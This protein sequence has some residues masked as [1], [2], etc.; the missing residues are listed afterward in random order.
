[1]MC[2]WYPSFRDTRAELMDDPASD[3]EKLE[4]TLKQF[5]F[6][7]RVL[8]RT[9]T[10]LDL[11]VLRD[12]R[13]RGLSEYSVLDIGAGACDVPMA[14]VAAARRRG[15]RLTVT[16]LDHDPRVVRYAR[17]RTA[18]LPEITVQEGSAFGVREKYQ[19]V[20][21]NHFLHHLTDQDLSRFLTGIYPVCEF[22]FVANDLLRSCWSVLGFRVFAALFL[23]NQSFARYDG[24]LSIRKG[25][26]PE[27]LERLVQRSSWGDQARVYRL[28]P[29]R[30]CIV[31]TRQPDTAPG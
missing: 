13:K 9:M 21:C 10:V 22:R 19:Y 6:I 12:M 23:G 26:R 16:C 7:N 1:M 11:F 28:M 18:G 5:G 20:I 14:L 15:L 27:E 31:G 25:F 2:R 30:V 8:S 17:T 24:E 29:G 4:A 3:P